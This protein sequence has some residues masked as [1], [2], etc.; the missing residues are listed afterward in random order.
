VE[1]SLAA[2]ELRLQQYTIAQLKQDAEYLVCF[3]ENNLPPVS[4]QEYVITNLRLKKLVGFMKRQKFKQ[5]LR[6]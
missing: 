5:E 3:A 2:F 6:R 1:A 4:Q